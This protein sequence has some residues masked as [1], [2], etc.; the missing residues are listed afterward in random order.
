MRTRLTLTFALLALTLPAVAAAGGWATAGLAP[1]PAGIDA[2]DTWRA[3]ITLLQ[4][5]RTP[6]EGVQPSITI[7][8]PTTETF[9]ASPSGK[10]GTYVAEVVFPTAGT[11]SYQ[12]DD[13]FSQVHT[14]KPVAVGIAPAG[15]VA[16][17]RFPAWA[18]ASI[19]AGALVLAAA[20]FV[21]VRRRWGHGVPALR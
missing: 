5:G 4:H 10:P 15:P 2:G 13:G 16:D 19:A 1:P 7:S 11:Y 17:G 9:A 20:A 6:L 3:E 12:V 8:G 14:F 21:L 18:F